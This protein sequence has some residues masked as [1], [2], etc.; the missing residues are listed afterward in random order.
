MGGVAGR[1]PERL[2]GL[3][4]KGEKRERDA[5]D[6]SPRRRRATFTASA[7]KSTLKRWPVS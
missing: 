7:E 6:A 5:G 2:S 4:P 1:H 3:P